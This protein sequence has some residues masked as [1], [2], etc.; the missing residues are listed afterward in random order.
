MSTETTNK[1][2]KID[3][4][5]TF[6]RTYTDKAVDELLKNAGGGGIST[7]NVNFETL[8]LDTSSLTAKDQYVLAGSDDGEGNMNYIPLQTYFFN[9]GY[10]NK[11]VK[12]QFSSGDFRLTLTELAFQSDTNYTMK[13]K[14]TNVDFTNT[15]DS[16]NTWTKLGDIKYI[17][18]EENEMMSGE[19]SHKYLEI[20]SLPTLPSDASSKTYTL[21][22][23]NGVLTWTD[24]IGDINTILD[25]INGEVI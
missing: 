22:T 12:M 9:A 19:S 3:N 2:I 18:I 6:G 1:K 21:Q 14:N 20:N 10:F 4:G 23:V 11:E 5:T 8:Q 25:N 24:A 17:A 15:L 7:A 16:T 13:C